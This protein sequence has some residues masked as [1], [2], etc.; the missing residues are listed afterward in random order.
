MAVP[1]DEGITDDSYYAMPD[2]CT[3]HNGS[4]TI[5]DP[6]GAEGSDIPYGPGYVPE[7]TAPYSRPANEYYTY[8][9][10]SGDGNTIPIVPAGPNG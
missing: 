7:T 8:P 2:Y 5:I 6:S 9:H 3:V 10:S 1:A 4:S